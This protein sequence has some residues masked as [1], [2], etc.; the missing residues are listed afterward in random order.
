[1]KKKT[2][3]EQALEKAL[4]EVAEVALYEASAKRAIKKIQKILE[5]LQKT[6]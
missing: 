5:N 4:V 1:M 3:K 6:L 2:A